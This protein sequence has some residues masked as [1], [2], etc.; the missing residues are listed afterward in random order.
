MRKKKDLRL[1]KNEKVPPFLTENT[2]QNPTR[3]QIVEME[4]KKKLKYTSCKGKVRK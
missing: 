3:N 4:G 1:L 2:K